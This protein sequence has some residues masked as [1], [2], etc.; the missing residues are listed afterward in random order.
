MVEICSA[1]RFFYKHCGKICKHCAEQV[2]ALSVFP[3]CRT[4]IAFECF[5][6]LQGRFAVGK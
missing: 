5:K 3:L 2:E 1:Y 6:I 4:T